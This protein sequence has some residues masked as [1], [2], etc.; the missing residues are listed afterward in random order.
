VVG[1]G[2]LS[3]DPLPLERRVSVEGVDVL[4]GFDF[5]TP[6]VANDVG[7]CSGIISAPGR[8]AECDRIALAQ[9]EYRH[10]MHFDWGG[11]W[12]ADRADAP[13]RHHWGSVHSDA[14]WVVFF[15]GGRGWLVNES[16]APGSTLEYKRGAIPPLGTFRT[17]VGAGLDF[18]S[19]GVFIAKALSDPHEPP[20]LFVRLKRSL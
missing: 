10:E 5:R 2:W 14:A 1:A 4:P 9:V 16:P 20:N 7:T 15:D 6:A 3:G 12:D 8:P 18:G 17:D 11:D 19:V 13:A